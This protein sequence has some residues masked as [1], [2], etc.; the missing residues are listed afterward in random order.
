[1]GGG[2]TPRQ[3]MVGMMYLV[4]LAM[5]AM[6]ASKSLLNAFV[7]LENGINKTVNNFANANAAFYTTIEK[8]A[9]SSPAYQV[10]L[11]EAAKPQESQLRCMRTIPAMATLS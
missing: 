2:G 5:L 8:A 4:L 11:D 1:M 10:K 3:Q 7:M 6:N 9:A